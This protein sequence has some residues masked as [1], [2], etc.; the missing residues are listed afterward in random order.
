MKKFFTLCLAVASIAF[1]AQAQT[2]PAVTMEE[3][4]IQSTTIDLKFIPNEATGN[5]YCC[6]FGQNELE[7]QFNVFGA[8]FGFQN[9]GDM[10]KA[11]GYANQGEQTKHWKDLNPGTTYEIWVLPCDLEDNYGELQCFNV[12]TL[13]QGG[14]GTSVIEIEIGE[15]GGDDENGHWQD[16]IYMPNDQ[17]AV[18]YDLICTQ[19][20]YDENGAQGVID[21]L[22][23]EADP[24]DPFA[25][26]YAHYELDYARWNAEVATIYHACAIGK[27]ALGEWGEFTDVIFATPGAEVALRSI[28]AAENRSNLT[29]NLQGQTVREGR[30]LVVR[31]GQKMLVK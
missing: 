10:I 25:A 7:E 3:V 23:A 29:F 16:V 8:W 4:D 1:T 13:G 20:F 11:W 19:E 6:L 31:N 27:N 5:Y 2:A 15:F 14:N 21:Y 22:K 24:S 28:E 9:Y 30:G 12:T 26:Y 18:F 17:T